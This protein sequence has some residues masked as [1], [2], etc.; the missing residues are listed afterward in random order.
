MSW[1]PWNKATTKRAPAPP[2]RRPVETRIRELLDAGTDYA[3]IVEQLAAD[4]VTYGRVAQ[5]ESLAQL[6]H[7]NDPP[8]AT[9][10][11]PRR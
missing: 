5:V 10:P 9:P 8:N 6:D 3:D 2:D 11:F 1:E 4:K 7:R